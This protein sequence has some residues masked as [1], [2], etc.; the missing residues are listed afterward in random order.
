MAKTLEELMVQYEEL[1][2]LV[3]DDIEFYF[4]PLS[5]IEFKTLVQKSFD[6]FDFEDSVSYLCLVHPED[7]DFQTCKAGI[8][9]MLCM[10]ILEVSGFGNATKSLELLDKARAEISQD[11]DAQMEATIMHIFP[12]YKAEDLEVWTRKKMFER[13]VQAEWMMA[14]LGMVPLVQEQNQNLPPPPG[15]KGGIPRYG[16]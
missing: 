11:L 15:P 7:F 16:R 4:R 14:S 5:R 9:A 12:A 3:I 6:G 13:Y 1:Y 2:R 10:S 8:P